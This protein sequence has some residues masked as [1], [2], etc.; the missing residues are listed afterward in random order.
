MRELR[1]VQQAFEGS[2]FVLEAENGEQFV[3]PIDQ[4]RDRAGTGAQA[5][6]R[7]EAPKPAPPAPAPWPGSQS[8]GGGAPLGPREIQL[9][10]RA[11]ESAEA[12]A[13]ESGMTLDRVLRFALPVL[14]ERGRITDEA[15]R[16]RARRAPGE[17]ATLPFGETVDRRFTAHGVD[18][19]SVRWDSR[20]REDRQWVV[21]ASWHREGQQYDAEWT[22]TRPGRIVGPVDDAAC[23]L[24]SDRP[25]PLPTPPAAP[26]LTLAAP[27][28]DPE[29]A[30]FPPMPE[31]STAPIPV[32]PA[33]PELFDQ[34]SS[35][36]DSAAAPDPWQDVE[37]PPLPLAVAEHENEDEPPIRRPKRSRSARPAG[38]HPSA[39]QTGGAPPSGGGQT[40]G[41]LPRAGQSGAE[42]PR[43]SSGDLPRA[44]RGSATRGSAARS[45]VPS[46]DDILL[47]VRRERD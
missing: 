32:L 47:G 28:V 9:R 44:A 37:S 36:P 19:A 39:R 16:A 13:E 43:Q 12:L 45:P 20:R 14:E 31:A 11:G 18:P 21:I 27:P 15:R 34:E 22:Y 38:E 24:L 6:Q 30:L 29:V 4:V 10:V 35:E 23:E 1:F 2:I 42:R 7:S 46:W 33:G 41:D 5:P 26:R 40:G 17:A 8:A 3:L 25:I